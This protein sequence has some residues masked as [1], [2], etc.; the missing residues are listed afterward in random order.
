[1]RL[2]RYNAKSAFC[3]LVWE[4]F[5]FFRPTRPHQ[6]YDTWRL[7][8]G[9]NL[10]GTQSGGIFLKFN[11]STCMLINNRPYLTWHIQ[12]TQVVIH[13]HKLFRTILYIDS[14][15]PV[16]AEFLKHSIALKNSL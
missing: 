4:K 16:S 15:L 12:Y 9:K 6:A 8:A 11:I 14:G 10:N 13:D 3:A 1:M 7:E 5:A 2:T